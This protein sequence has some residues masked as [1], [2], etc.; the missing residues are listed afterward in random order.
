LI[1]GQRPEPEIEDSA[2]KH[3]VADEDMLHAVRNA[4]REARLEDL[5]MLIGPAADGSLLEIGLLDF[6][7]D[8]PTII[9]AMPAR[10]KFLRPKKAR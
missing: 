3:G 1:S 10:E 4:I 6:D 9:H 8:D 2:R 5:T 7:G